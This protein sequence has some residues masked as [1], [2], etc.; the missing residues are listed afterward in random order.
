ML[1]PGEAAAIASMTAEQLNAEQ[2]R[3]LEE[4]F[5]SSLRSFGYLTT[6]EDRAA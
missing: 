6:A 5:T 1:P 2:L 4:A 3:Q